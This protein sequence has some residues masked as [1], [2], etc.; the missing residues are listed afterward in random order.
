MILDAGFLIS[1]DRGERS[2]RAAVLAEEAPDSWHTSHPV[3]A[4]V[5]RDGSSQARLAAFLK[6]VT[7]H[8][9]DNGPA[10]GRLLA[11]SGTSDV[12]DAHLVVLAVRLDDDILTADPTDLKTISDSLG[13]SG[14][15]I[16]P[17][18]S[19]GTR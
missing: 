12:V 13:S 1:V 14:P 11:R 6:H 15:S 16:R 5:W 2:A 7:V 4:Q 18:P 19:H 8:P 17:W 9:F 3:V 10:V